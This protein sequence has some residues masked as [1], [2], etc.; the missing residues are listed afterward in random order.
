M[1]LPTQYIN[2]LKI[3]ITN[4]IT[5]IDIP[6]DIL[7]TLNYNIKELKK[8]IKINENEA[9]YKTLMILAVYYSIQFQIYIEKNEYRNNHWITIK[10]ENIQIKETYFLSLQ[11]GNN[12]YRN[13]QG[14]YSALTNTNDISPTASTIK[15][16]LEAIKLNMNLKYEPD[17]TII[18]I[19][20]WNAKSILDYTK[21]AFLIQQIREHETNISSLVLARNSLI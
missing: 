16:T 3:H 18:N 15:S 20:I 17:L 9:G 21:K 4:L 14:K 13:L 5:E 6:Q 11:Q 1:N 12:P 10:N 2:Q 7:Q 19:M 8:Q